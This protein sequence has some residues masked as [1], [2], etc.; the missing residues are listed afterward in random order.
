M[1][2][3]FFFNKSW[4][5]SSSVGMY[6]TAWV[7]GSPPIEAPFTPPFPLQIYTGCSNPLPFIHRLQQSS[8]LHIQAAAILSP[9]YTGYS[10][11]LPF[12]YML[13]QSSPFIYR[14]QQSSPFIY[15]L[16]QSC[17][18]TYFFVVSLL[19][20]LCSDTLSHPSP[21]ETVDIPRTCSR[22]WPTR[23]RGWF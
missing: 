20:P 23:T 2:F 11:P 8:P 7:L 3:F 9:S 10:N 19:P 1:I 13:Q 4:G 12:I 22:F 14:L 16:Q 15:R 18:P 17:V 5:P 6:L 21:I